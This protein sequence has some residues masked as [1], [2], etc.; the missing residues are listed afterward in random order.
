MRN[1]LFTNGLGISLLRFCTLIINISIQDN[2]HYNNR[3][4]Q[5][6]RL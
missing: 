1:L 2:E 6:H 3:R 4:Q 5:W